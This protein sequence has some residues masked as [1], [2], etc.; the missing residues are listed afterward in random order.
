MH[1]FN[2]P[3]THKLVC[4]IRDELMAKGLTVW[5]ETPSRHKNEFGQ[6]KKT[7][8]KPDGLE[9]TKVAVA[10]INSDYLQKVNANQN[11]Y[12]Q[13]E[14]KFALTLVGG[15]LMLPVLLDGSLWNSRA[16]KGELGG[17]LGTH[18]YINMSDASSEDAFKAKCSELY[19]AIVGTRDEKFYITSQCFLSHNWANDSM[20][21]NNHA[22]VSKINTFLK[23]KKVITWFDEETMIGDIR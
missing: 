12:I 19:E 15:R 2:N 18:L 17:A 3:Q 1:D 10:L 16:W 6:V 21:R 22:R 14:F 9:N 4:S 8:R 11:S 7:Y 23:N 13:Y 20:G 5:I